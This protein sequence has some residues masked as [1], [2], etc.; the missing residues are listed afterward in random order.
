M[1]IAYAQMP[2][3]NAHTGVSS[4]ALSLNFGLILHL[5]PYFVYA[6]SEGSCESA[7]MQTEKYRYLVHWP[8]YFSTKS[9][10][11]RHEISNKS[12]Q[13][14]CLTLEYFMTDKLLTEH[15]LEFLSLKGDCTGSSESTLVKMPHFWKSHVAYNVADTN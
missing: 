5:P 11:Q 10:E 4:K 15:Q 6:N 14:L 1:L 2:R 13:S 7:H 9:Y 3:N 8:I 12:D